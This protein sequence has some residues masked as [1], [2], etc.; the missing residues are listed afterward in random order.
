MGST[1]TVGTKQTVEREALHAQDETPAQDDDRFVSHSVR[2]PAPA[3]AA[4]SRQRRSLTKQKK[5]TP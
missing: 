5:K 1:D 4:I 3:V 2:I